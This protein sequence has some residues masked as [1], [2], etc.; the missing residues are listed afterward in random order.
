MPHVGTT[1][2]P[3]VQVL[4]IL[5]GQPLQEPLLT[6]LTARRKHPPSRHSPV[7][8]CRVV[9]HTQLFTPPVAKSSMWAKCVVGLPQSQAHGMLGLHSI[10]HAS[11]PWNQTVST[12]PKLPALRSYLP[13]AMDT[14]CV[15][16]PAS[17]SPLS[18]PPSCSLSHL[19]QRAMTPQPFRAAHEPGR[20]SIR[21]T[22]CG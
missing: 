13:R 6:L 17:T 22:L 7:P 15:S 19:L 3:H 4:P 8:H 5:P 14:C 11:L 1:P 12:S 21:A 9:I 18:I 16:L 20:P 2:W 10:L